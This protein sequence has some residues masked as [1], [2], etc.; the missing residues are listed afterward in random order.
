V[1]LRSK[2][3]SHLYIEKEAWCYSATQTICERFSHAQHITINHYKDVFNRRNQ[4]L[5]LQKQNRKLILALKRPPYLYAGSHLIQDFGFKHYL[6]APIMM[7]CLYDC[8]YC[9]LQGMYQSGNI[10]FFVNIEDYLHEAHRLCGGE[11]KHLS[12]SY[13]TDL[14]AFEGIYPITHRWIESMRSCPNVMIEVRT[15]SANY[16]TLSDI[17][18][19]KN[20]ILSWTLSP[21]IVIQRYE[22][23]S[24]SLQQRITSVQNALDGGWQ[25]R[26]CFD[27]IVDL[28]FEEFESLYASFF[29]TVFSVLDAHRIHD[30]AL[31]LL[32]FSPNHLK[33]IKR[34]GIAS[35]IV[36]YPYH[37]E[38]NTLSYDPKKRENMSNFIQGILQR[39]FEKD[40]IF[41]A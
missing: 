35:D 34:K 10:V 3:F 9:I 16:R 38:S 11:K 30:V 20:V 39:Y 23:Y 40:K 6:Y 28:P 7:N 32:R 17:A 19:P 2:R 41:V 13:D 24:A 27:P 5:R 8:D 4:D 37:N 21:E 31:G 15:K 22:H 26:L 1:L 36:Y 14:L 12:I 29:E 18:A 25:V 33:A